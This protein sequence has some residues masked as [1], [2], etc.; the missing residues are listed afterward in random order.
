MRRLLQ[1]PR[2]DSLP[3]SRIFFNSGSVGF[4]S[5]S[6]VPSN[7]HSALS[8]FY[9]QEL[10]V[11][12]LGLVARFFGKYPEYANRASLFVKG[13]CLP[14]RL[15]VG[16]SRTDIRRSRRQHPQSSA[17]KGAARSVSARESRSELLDE[18]YVA[19]VLNELHKKEKFDFSGSV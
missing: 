9:G 19:E 7:S 4:H 16:E 11:V 13:R 3:P 14:G 15:Y 8:G 17:W 5:M 1:L 18:H 2:I 12:N 6:L 10:T